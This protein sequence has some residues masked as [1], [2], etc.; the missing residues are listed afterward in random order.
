MKTKETVEKQ[1]N[2]FCGLVRDCLSERLDREEENMQ[3]MGSLC[4]ILDCEGW[5]NG[6]GFAEDIIY[7]LYDHFESPLK[8]GGVK[9]SAADMLFQWHELVHYATD[10][11][12]VTGRD[13]M[14]T[15]RLIFSSPRS[16]NWTDILALVELLFTVPISNAKLERMFSKMKRVITVFRSSTKEL[17]LENILRIMEDDVSWENYDPVSAIHHWLSDKERRVGEEDGPREYKK[18]ASKRTIASLSD[19]SEDELN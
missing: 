12:G 14:K 1:K 3:L 19:S 5:K 18:R 9:C 10:T 13:Y 16:E 6:E 8:T 17:R 2:Y 15:W 11:I 4:T 7:D